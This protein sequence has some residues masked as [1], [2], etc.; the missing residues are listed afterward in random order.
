MT[1]VTETIIQRLPRHNFKMIYSVRM[2]MV[3]CICCTHSEVVKG[4][5]WQATSCYVFRQL[6]QHLWVLGLRDQWIRD[7]KADK[8][9]SK[10]HAASHTSVYALTCMAMILRGMSSRCCLMLKCQVFILI[11]SSNMNSRYK[12]PSTQTYGSSEGRGQTHRIRYTGLS[13]R[14]WR[15]P[16]KKVPNR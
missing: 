1:Y 15:D 9:I 13:T 7:N 14:V 3:R 10:L 6:V 8:H 5:V 12:R 2:L 11:M 4:W 16:F